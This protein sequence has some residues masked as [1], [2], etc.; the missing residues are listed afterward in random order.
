VGTIHTARCDPADSTTFHPQEA[1]IIEGETHL[2]LAPEGG[3]AQSGSHP[4][5]QRPPTL[6]SSSSYLCEEAEVGIKGILEVAAS[7]CS[8]K[9]I[10]DGQDCNQ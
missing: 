6:Y 9:E 7:S 1:E 8:S 5:V 10:I 2:I 4:W 3:A